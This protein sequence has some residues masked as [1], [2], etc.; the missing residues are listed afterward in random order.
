MLDCYSTFS[1]G[2]PAFLTASFQVELRISDEFFDATTAATENLPL[3]IPVRK[4]QL[5][6][7]R[8]AVWLAVF[9]FGIFG[10]A[11]FAEPAVPKIEK[12]IGLIQGS[13]GL[14]ELALVP[15]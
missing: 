7:S 1:G 10:A 8:W 9:A 4:W 15:A 11:M 14:G 6:I 5:L 3:G 2:K 12:V 13:G